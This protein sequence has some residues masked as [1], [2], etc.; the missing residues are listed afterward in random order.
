M[1]PQKSQGYL[2]EHPPNPSPNI[3]LPTLISPGLG[4]AQT[5]ETQSGA[6]LCLAAVLGPLR[7]VARMPRGLA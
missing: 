1:Q 6:G 5:T 3:T 2:E 7:K 4:Q